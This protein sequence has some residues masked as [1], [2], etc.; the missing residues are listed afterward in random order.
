MIDLDSTTDKSSIK[1]I[2]YA[3]PV[4]TDLE[5]D[6]R[7]E[8]VQPTGVGFT[9][10]ITASGALHPKVKTIMTDSV[11]APVVATDLTGDSITG[12]T[13]IVDLY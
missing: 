2:I 9:Y 3:S 4:L 10:I 8:I 11:L 5:N 7:L 13:C 12:M 6:G 1:A